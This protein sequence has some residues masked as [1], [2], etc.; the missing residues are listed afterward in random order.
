V[1]G[2]LGGKEDDV[3]SMHKS[4]ATGQFNIPLTRKANSCIATNDYDE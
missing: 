4:H 1:A 3:I 2:C